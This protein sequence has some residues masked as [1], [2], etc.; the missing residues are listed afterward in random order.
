M[1][2]GGA[3]TA[4]K[5]A[6]F[7]RWAGGKR[8]LL[9]KLPEILGSFQVVNYHE[10]FLGGG[11]VFLGMSPTGE[12]YLSDLNADLVETYAQV[13]DHPKEVARVLATHPNRSK[14]YYDLR[15][16]RPGKAIDRAAR[17]IYLNHTSFNGIYRVNLNG[18]YNVPFGSREF[19]RIPTSEDL[20]GVSKRLNGATITCCD[21][22]EA[23]TRVGAGDLVFL[24]PP[25]TVAHNDNGFVKYN[26]KLFS[27][28]DQERL[29]LAIETIRKKKAYYILTNA[30]HKSIS[31]LFDSDDR[32]LYVARRNS[33][34]GL[35]AERGT[36]RE[37]VFTN[38]PST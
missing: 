8:W 6:P 36:A 16:A 38:L 13:R 17:F 33:V 15:A 4:T 19:L 34:G 3:Q 14:H 35:N 27:F 2:A 30:A 23:V 21:F 31:D 11:S 12:S 18:E 28:A 10:P 37:F 7:L 29:Q 22:A 9:P 5:V 32:K 1:V 25:Y 24:D 20:V 26:Q